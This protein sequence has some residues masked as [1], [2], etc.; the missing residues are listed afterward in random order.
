[1]TDDYHTG[2]RTIDDI[3]T[4]DEVIDDDE[5]FVWGDFS[6]ED[7]KKALEKGVVTVY[8]SKPITNGNFVSTSQNQA[9]DYAG[10]GK[11]YSQEVS[12]EDVAWISGDEGQYAK[13]KELIK[14]NKGRTLTKEQQEYF[15]DSKVRDENGNLQTV[16]HGTD[17]NFTIFD[18]SLSDEDNVL[19]Q[20]LYF[21]ANKE[22][23]K[24]YG[25]KQYE[26]YLNI[27]NPLVI[28]DLTTQALANKIQSIEPNANI[29]D[30]NYGV[31]STEKMTNYLIENGYD[32]IKAGNDV[33]VA[34]DSNQVKNVDNIKP[35]ENDDI[36]YSLEGKTRSHYETIK[37]S[38]MVDKTGK[39][40]AN[41]LLKNERY[42]PL[43]NSKAINYVEK[44]LVANGINNSY[45]E[46]KNKLNSNDRMTVNDI[47][48]GERLIQ[49]LSKTGDFDTVSDLIQDVAVLGTELGQQV[50]AMSLINKM[51][52]EGQLQL[53]TKTINRLNKT[54]ENLDTEIELSKKSRDAILKAD[55]KEALDEAVSK[56][57]IEIAEQIPLTTSDKLRSW[58]YLSMLGNPRTHIRNILSNVAMKGTQTVK[59]KVAGA[60]EDVVNPTERTK[61]FKTANKETKKFAS[62]DADKIQSRL[63]DGGHEDI[64]S[65]VK[66]NKRSFDN[67]T[68]NKISEFNSNMLEKEDWIFLKSA[69]KNSLA[70]Y[71][72][73]NELT[74]EYLNSGSKEANVALEK[75]R[76]YA[77]SQAQEATFRQYSQ[78]ASDISRIENRN[79]VS[80]FIVG[81]ALPFKKTPINIAKAG[82]EYSPIGLLKATKEFAFDIKK[83]N[84][85]VN[86]AIDSLA[87]GLTGTSIMG[88]GML[89]AS[90]GILKASGSDDE[91]EEKYSQS[92]GNQNYSIKIGDST[93]TL[94]WLSPTAMPLFAGAELWNATQTDNDFNLNNLVDASLKTINPL[95]EMSMLQSFTSALTSYNSDGTAGKLSD[96]A[97]NVAE[98]YAGQFVPTLLGQVARTIDDTER[99]TSYSDKTGI[100]KELE[101]FTNRIVAKIPVASMTLQPKTDIWGNEVKRS[102]SLLVRAGENM[103]APYYKKN[104]QTSQVDTELQRVYKETGEGV[105]PS[106][107]NSKVTI[108]KTPY[109]L[110]PEDYTEYKKTYG[111]IA[112]TSLNKIISTKE[113]KQLDDEE[114]AKVI[115]SVYSDALSDSKEAYANKNDITYEKST[116]DIKVDDLV[117]NGLSLI[118]SYI[119][120]GEISK[121]EGTKNSDGKTVSGST[122]GNKAKYI[123]DMNTSDTQKDKLLSL[124]NDSE[125]AK[126]VTVSDLNKIDKSSYSTFFG[127]SATEDSKGNS[128]RDKYLMLREFDIECNELDKYMTQIGKITGDK[129]EEGKTIKNSKLIKVFQMIDELNIE[130]LQKVALLVKSGYTSETEN[131]MSQYINSLDVSNQRKIEILN[132]LYDF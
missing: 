15:K 42:I 72:T 125:K 93:Y 121:I 108:N 22:Q 50:Q 96:M 115:Q 49:E 64:M 69:Y 85:T 128:Q 110:S 102:D 132:M 29:I 58:R 39:E 82:F 16:Y 66:I 43:K 19:G 33:Y 129:D 55:S 113:Y 59:N 9:R 92:L 95:M 30:F 88:I 41:N 105:L 131:L 114:K 71:M 4:F 24:K 32:G 119:Y 26:T 65:K 130:P 94:D 6:Q 7:A 51:T 120:K 84:K 60:I 80:K 107:P 61:T 83:G 78:L 86:Q 106:V 74:S 57:T 52:P 104:I 34:F 2:I 28:D 63:T 23:S 123:M 127:L 122:Q 31:A 75:A 112:K 54:T 1:M 21:T 8:S 44:K 89:L 20:G 70:N 38:N 37:N 14:D 62:L 118:N 3:K 12:L 67:K 76:E 68:L 111:N 109:K 5:S 35:T 27:K 13:I 87:K 91:K 40:I 81:G 126:N 17:S 77:I 10:N 73:A 103:L 45:I 25:N 116:T 46:F 18:K 101:T 47:A 117:N 100:S 90:Q 97:L 48:M 99:D 124:L 56:A 53:L 98:S 79:A 11:I 36:R